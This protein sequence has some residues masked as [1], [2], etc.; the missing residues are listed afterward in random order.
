MH[1]LGTGVPRCLGVAGSASSPKAAPGVN[2]QRSA[3][4]R[5]SVSRSTYLR[6]RVVTFSVLTSVSLPGKLVV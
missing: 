3:T 5:P 1:V 2:A 6:S 4:V